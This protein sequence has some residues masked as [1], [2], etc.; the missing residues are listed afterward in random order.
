MMSTLAMQYL[1][2]Y[3]L[4][5]YEDICKRTVHNWDQRLQD[6]KTKNAER[7]AAFAEGELGLELTSSEVQSILASL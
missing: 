3:C 7:V 5:K 1:T 6:L 4:W 2:F